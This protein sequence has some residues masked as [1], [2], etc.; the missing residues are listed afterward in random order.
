MAMRFSE[1]DVISMLQRVFASTDSRISIGIGDDAAV[2]ATSPHSI[3]TTDM[4]VE[5]VHFNRDWSSAFDIGRKITAA[6]CADILAMGGRCDYLVAAISLTGS[7]E[8]SWL[9]NL[10]Q[11]M[12]HEATLAGATIV[13]GDIS[14]G[15]EI[16]IAMTA[17]GTSHNAITRSGAQIGDSIYLSSLTGWSAAGLWLLT[18]NVSVDSAAA[19]LAL[20][21]FSAPTIDYGI[22]F[23]RATSC[24]DTSDSLLVQGGQIAEASGVQLQIDT[25]LFQSSTE[26]GPLSALA[27]GVGV[28]VWQWILAGGE[29]H[30][31]LATG[32]E[33]PGVRIGQ[34]CHGEGISGY[35]MKKA[36]VS[37]SHFLTE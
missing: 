18:H 26:F 17:L 12:R 36:P 30:V 34:V 11:G 27:E 1:G 33:L 15:S 37:W 16:V 14:R 19:D 21:Q 32:Q 35:D 25:Q 7:E 20:A 10:A 31:L 23:S 24:A 28:D 3:V 13:G 9:E 29:D 2:V 22:D 5:G 6:N 8:F 4:A